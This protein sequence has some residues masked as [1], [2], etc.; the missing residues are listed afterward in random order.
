MALD[1][2][3]VRYEEDANDMLRS[4]PSNPRKLAYK[5][6]AEQPFAKDNLVGTYIRDFGPGGKNPISD[7]S[8]LEIA[9]LDHLNA[10]VLAGTLTTADAAN[11]VGTFYKQ[12]TLIQATATKYPLITDLPYKESY[13]IK[14]SNNPLLGSV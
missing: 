13:V 4:S 8:K 10:K 1:A 11:Q 14:L 9:M 5:F 2:L 3:H 12:A 7:N 6:M